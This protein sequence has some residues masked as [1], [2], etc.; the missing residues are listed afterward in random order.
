MF[1]LF[2]SEGCSSCPP[3]DAVA[4]K[5]VGLDRDDLI[6]LAYHVDYWD[7]LGWADRFGSPQ[8]T[9]RQRTYA[10]QL[11]SGVYT[12]Q[13]VVGGT[14]QAVGSSGR[15]LTAILKR[16]LATSRPAAIDLA[17]ADGQMV[18]VTLPE[19]IDGRGTLHVALV[20]RAAASEVERGENA[21]RRLRHVNLVRAL[22]SQPIAD[23]TVATREV[24]I[25]RP[26]DGALLAV[27]FVQADDGTIG[28]AG[29]T[30][31]AAR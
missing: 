25:P 20:Q 11:E 17:A 23:G 5:L 9:A 4:A 29:V 31:V 24:A 27:A 19:R 21:G 1:E 16:Q 22:V 18:T 12:P 3:A 6:V 15:D 30:P 26:D 2:T 14:E 7:R 10:R 8:W 28:A 13:A